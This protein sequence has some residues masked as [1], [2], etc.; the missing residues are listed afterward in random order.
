VTQTNLIACGINGVDV[1]MDEGINWNAV[2][3]TGFHVCRK[4]KRGK[5]VFLAGADGRIGKVLW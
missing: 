5:A 4:A 3:S 2:S 1:S